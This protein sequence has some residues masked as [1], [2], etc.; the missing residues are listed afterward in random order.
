MSYKIYRY[1]FPNGK[2]YIGKTK[3]SIEQRAGSNGCRYNDRT[4]V[5]R[6]IRKYGW[7]NVKKEILL[8]NLSETEANKQEREFIKRFNTTN[9]AFGYNLTRGGDGGQSI[10]RVV[11]AETRK[12]IGENSRKKLKG[13][14]VPKEQVERMRKTLTG[15]IVTQETRE[16]IRKANI[17]KTHS[18]ETKRKLSEINRN[19]DPA[20]LEKI[21]QS[22]KKS[23]PE[24]A[25]KRK[26]TLRRKHP[27]GI[28][29]SEEHKAKLSVA[30]KGKKKSEETKAKMCKPKSQE[31]VE[32]MREAQRISHRAR[33]LGMTYREYKEQQL[34]NLMGGK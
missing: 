10:H 9:F 22:L 8:D 16:K 4:L 29:L 15:H 25:A 11:S 30:M 26:E 18:A 27:E 33:K 20:I 19:R 5:G 14:K 32:K 13:R 6:A 17:G 12:K 2:Y 3:T 1:T 28:H 7:I 21:S 23:G 34:T 24:R 31:T